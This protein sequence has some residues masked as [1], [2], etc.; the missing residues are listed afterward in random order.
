MACEN[1]MDEPF[2]DDEIMQ[3]IIE[4]SQ[5]HVSTNEFKSYIRENY[6]S[7]FDIKPVSEHKDLLEMFILNHLRI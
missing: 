3:S 7:T 4:N 6:V 2:R 5:S 1:S